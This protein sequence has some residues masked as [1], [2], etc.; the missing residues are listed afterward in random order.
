MQ[1]CLRR[2]LAVQAHPR[3]TQRPHLLRHLC[4]HGAQDCRGIMRRL[5]RS[6]LCRGVLLGRPACFRVLIGRQARRL[7]LHCLAS[8]I[9]GAADGPSW[10]LW[11]V[12]LAVAAEWSL[13]GIVARVP[14][15]RRDGRAVGSFR[16][17]RSLFLRLALSQ[18]DPVNRETKQSAG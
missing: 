13:V 3:A 18:V 12:A 7:C 8:M 5:R 2:I 16:A 15:A 14:C 10:V 6:D 9:A 1:I 17:A 4:E 11:R